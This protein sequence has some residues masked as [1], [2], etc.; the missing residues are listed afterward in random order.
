MNPSADAYALRIAALHR[1]LGLP[2]D[3]AAHRGLPLQ[4]EAD[5]A[6]LVTIAQKADGTRVRL[7]PPA[8]AAW[9]AMHA[10]ASAAGHEL[11]P[12]SGF[13][14]V[15][16]QAAIIRTHLAAGRPLADLLAS[17]AAPGF[18]EHHTGRALDLGTPGEPPLEDGFAQTPA[19]AWLL[20]H[21]PSHGF[22]LSYPAGNHHG[23]VFEPWHW[24]WRES[25]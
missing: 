8:A 24:C 7:L 10:A 11:Q 15:D 22:H 17:V 1:E 3:Y 14:S 25:T 23:I 6:A 12:L 16:R 18:S 5:E 19:Y 21:A 20:A 2:A 13:R 4:A 9:R